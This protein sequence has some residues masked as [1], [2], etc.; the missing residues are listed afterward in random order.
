M[1][2]CVAGDSDC[3]LGSYAAG[4][5]YKNGVGF[6]AI[7]GLVGDNYHGAIM[8]GFS[9]TKIDFD[10]TKT[11]DNL[12]RVVD[13]A[14]NTSGVTQLNIS[15]F[16]T[17][18]SNG[19]L[20]IG[21]LVGVSNDIRGIAA[22]ILNS[23]SS[24]DIDIKIIDGVTHRFMPP[25]HGNLQ[26]IYLYN[27]DSGFG[28]TSIGVGGIAGFLYDTAVNNYYDGNIR[29][30][31]KTGKSIEFDHKLTSANYS[32]DEWSL[33]AADDGN[34]VYSAVPFTTDGYYSVRYTLM[35]DNGNTVMY[36]AGHATQVAI[37][38][39]FGWV[40]TSREWI[41]NTM[42]IIAEASCAA[43]SSPY[44][45]GKEGL[46]SKCLGFNT[47]FL[48]GYT[49]TDSTTGSSHTLRGYQV[50]NNFAVA[51]ANSFPLTPSSTAWK[52][53]YDN[54]ANHMQVPA[55]KSNLL[56]SLSGGLGLVA[57][58]IEIDLK[59]LSTDPVVQQTLVTFGQSLISKWSDIGGDPVLTTLVQ[60][61]Q[62][63]AR[64]CGGSNGSGSNAAG[65]ASSPGIPRVPDTGLDL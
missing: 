39:L 13:E 4:G 17:T 28:Y 32:S 46:Y 50:A 57:Q 18:S 59:A 27:S 60:S 45:V 23:Y 3:T 21:G 65:G 10:S 63:V 5:G 22:C 41:F 37:G 29:V 11:L 35:Y 14:Q 24:S 20:H 6:I 34:G 33:T 40:G 15:S 25:D 16:V 8:N 53:G 19:Q 1:S 31:G 62:P 36:A 51:R 49:A 43:P 58:M 7:G 26:S 54:P 12:Q 48:N 44:D 47:V 38:Q 30:N 2:K 52:T 56:S 42:S 61:P 64:P 9:S 55:S